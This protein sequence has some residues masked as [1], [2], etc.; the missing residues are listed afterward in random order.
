MTRDDDRRRVSDAPGP[1]SASGTG[2][3]L[4]EAISSGDSPPRPEDVSPRRAGED[5][6]RL[7]GRV[8]LAGMLRAAPFPTD[9]AGLTEYLLAEGAPAPTVEALKALPAGRVFAD[10]AAVSSALDA[11]E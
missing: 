9:R 2:G 10:V 5:P 3:V 1:P 8:D 4:D 11:L 6:A 7:A